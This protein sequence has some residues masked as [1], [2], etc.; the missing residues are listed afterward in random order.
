MKYQYKSNWYLIRGV[1]I[2]EFYLAETL[3]WYLI[4]GVSA[5]EFYLAETLSYN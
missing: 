3:N 1:S 2:R 4:R 5:R